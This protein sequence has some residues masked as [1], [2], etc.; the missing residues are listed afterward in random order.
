M[1]A[2][3]GHG[4]SIPPKP[5]ISLEPDERRKV[6]LESL[7]A[8]H[9]PIREVFRTVSANESRYISQFSSGRWRESIYHGSILQSSEDSD[10]D[11]SSEDAL[12]EDPQKLV[13]Y[14]YDLQSEEHQR[15]A[16]MIMRWNLV[17]REQHFPNLEK[18]YMEK[19]RAKDNVKYQDVGVPQSPPLQ[20]AAMEVLPST[21]GVLETSSKSPRKVGEEPSQDVPMVESPESPKPEQEACQESPETVTEACKESESKSLGIQKSTNSKEKASVPDD[22]KLSKT[23]ESKMETSGADPKLTKGSQSDVSQLA[24]SSSESKME[25]SGAD[26]ELAK[27]SSESDDSKLAK[28]ASESETEASGASSRG[29]RKADSAAT[30]DGDDPDEKRTR[31]TSGEK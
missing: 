21:G 4:T 9:T 1:A 28:K 30:S 31:K 17:E 24:K 7:R 12:K 23:S 5:L 25:T 13:M 10:T 3:A 8:D 18:N 29:K 15:E 16:E 11:D 14:G 27:G 19:R 22:S 2:T 26:S 20:D 6:L